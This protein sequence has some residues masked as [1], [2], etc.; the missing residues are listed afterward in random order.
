MQLMYS[1]M[2]AKSNAGIRIMVSRMK[3]YISDILNMLD[4]R[5]AKADEIITRE[6][7]S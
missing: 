3:W 4:W 2:N 6:N 5:G 1:L 7:Y